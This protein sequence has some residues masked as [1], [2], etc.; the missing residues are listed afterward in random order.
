M[1]LSGYSCSRPASSN[2][3]RR[4]RSSGAR[5]LPLAAL[6]E[7]G[8]VE[9]AANEDNECTDT[10]APTAVKAPTKARASTKGTGPI[11]RSKALGGNKRVGKG[12]ARTL[13]KCMSKQHLLRAALTPPPPPPPPPHSNHEVQREGN[14]RTQGAFRSPFAHPVA[15]TMCCSRMSL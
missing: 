15:T 5:S 4:A 11:W 7:G 6:V 3:G 1:K 14:D 2:Q 13:H 10:R 8:D 9:G 12:R